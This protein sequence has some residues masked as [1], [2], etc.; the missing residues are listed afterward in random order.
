MKEGTNMGELI[1]NEGEWFTEIV[2]HEELGHQL[3]LGSSAWA[4]YKNAEPEN[5]IEGGYIFG[6]EFWEFEGVKV[7]L[8]L[9]DEPTE[10]T[11]DFFA[12]TTDRM[13]SF[14]F[15]PPPISEVVLYDN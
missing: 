14:K 11:K 3:Q 2:V 13:L 5:W 9:G 1:N 8:N 15:R 10:E 4:R 7:L 6:L 12:N